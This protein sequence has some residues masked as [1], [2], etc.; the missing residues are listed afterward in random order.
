M[1][2]ITHPE[3]PQADTSGGLGHRLR[4]CPGGRP[5]RKAGISTGRTGL[6]ARGALWCGVPARSGS[7]PAERKPP[8]RS[9]PTAGTMR[10]PPPGVLSGRARARGPD[11]QL[12]ALFSHAE[13][14]RRPGLKPGQPS[15]WYQ[16]VCPVPRERFP[17][18][19]VPRSV[20]GLV[21]YII[22]R[23][24]AARILPRGLTSGYARSRLCASF[25]V[26]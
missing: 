2:G 4:R 11:R 18:R 13:R 12:N 7:P 10:W 25:V 1:A 23:F 9:L 17:F 14:F 15:G 22:P 20:Q 16:P 5:P 21:P 3:W 6:M 19:M 26:Q 8:D 24:A